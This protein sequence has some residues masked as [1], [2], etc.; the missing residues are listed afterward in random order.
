MYH[1]K[2]SDV[3]PQDM[4]CADTF[5][6][7]LRILV[8]YSGKGNALT[9]SFISAE[10]RKFNLLHRDQ[11]WGP[12]SALYVSYRVVSSSGGIKTVKLSLFLINYAP[13]HEGIWWS[14]GIAP[15]FLTSA[16]D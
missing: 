8:I 11:S 5:S 10:A 7:E 4:R 15:P 2:I 14:G 16:P 1:R 12:L 3:P 9:K 13:R 6:K